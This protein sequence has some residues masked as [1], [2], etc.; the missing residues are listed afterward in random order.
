MYLSSSGASGVHDALATR[1]VTELGEAINGYSV[2]GSIVIRLP[3]GWQ[4]V[5][6]GGL[7]AERR[8][9]AVGVLPTA[10][11]VGLRGFAAFSGPAAVRKHSRPQSVSH[12]GRSG[13]RGRRQP[14]HLRNRE[15]NTARP[16]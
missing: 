4:D 6:P 14:Y 5:E 15:S 2:S 9:A 13:K 11:G 1:D 12:I 8:E 3:H 7:G 10:A 16:R